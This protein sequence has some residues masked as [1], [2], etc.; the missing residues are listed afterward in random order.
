MNADIVVVSLVVL[1]GVGLLCGLMLAVASRL[2][3]V[4]TDPRIEALENILPGGNCG[5]CGFPSCHAYAQNMVESGAE[6]NRC[7]LGVDKAD[8]ISK[9]LGKEVVAAES[10]V[11]AIKCYGGNTAVKGFDYDGLPSCRAASL[12]G[13]GDR[14]CKH[15]CLGFG[16][17]VEAC[18]FGALSRAGRDAPRVDRDKCTGCGNCTKVCPKGVIVLIPRK[19]RTL[20]ACNSEEKGKV[21]RKICEMGCISCG[22]CIKVCPEDALSMKDGRIWMDYSRCTNCG[23]CIEECPRKTIKDINP[24]ESAPKVANQ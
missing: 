14:L 5:G 1:G 12:Y 13:G 9:V 4:K 6:P 3:A 11:A 17:C 16:D 18:P 7:V 19:A 10:R 22:R 20:I 21:V 2:F 15:S 24:P 8:D 23:H